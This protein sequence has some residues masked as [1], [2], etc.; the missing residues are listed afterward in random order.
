MLVDLPARVPLSVY[1]PIV[2]IIARA[3]GQSPVAERLAEGVY[4]TP[5][6]FNYHL[7]Q[8][9]VLVTDA[10]FDEYAGWRRIMDMPRET[11]ED[12]AANRAAVDK[13]LSQPK[14]YGVC[15]TWEQILA[16]WPELKTMDRTFVIGVSPIYRADQPSYGGWRWHK[17]GEYIGS[18]DPQY[19]Y[20]YDEK[21]IDV[22]YCF[23]IYEVKV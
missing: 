13:L 16:K 1:D 19:E 23:A 5:I 9:G 21:G 15:D 14:D 8:Y 6:N 12:L 7:Q 22:V 20:L 11:D 10:P 2:E 3:N 4:Q 17:W 18:H